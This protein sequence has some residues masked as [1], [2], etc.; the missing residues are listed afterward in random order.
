MDKC[1]CKKSFVAG[2]ERLGTMAPQEMELQ[3]IQARIWGL[4]SHDVTEE[5]DVTISE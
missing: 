4:E 5:D 2:C 3:E 1:S